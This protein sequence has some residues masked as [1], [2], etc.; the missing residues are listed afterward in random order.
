MSPHLTN[1][2]EKNL[3]FWPTEDDSD[4]GQLISLETVFDKAGDEYSVLL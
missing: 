3:L 2:H 4:L 1:E